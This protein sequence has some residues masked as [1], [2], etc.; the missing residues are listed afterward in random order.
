MGLKKGDIVLV[1]FPFTDL[2]QTKFRPAVVLAANLAINEFTV[3]FVSSQKVETL[4]GGE[5]ALLE[6]DPDFSQ[7]GLRISSK[8]RVTRITT[9]SKQLITR[10]MG[11]LSPSHLQ[12]LDAT[13]IQAFQ[14]SS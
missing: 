1:E 14:L 12:Q 5:S 8:V 13:L 3:C 2:S 6:S 10:R 4:Y 7:T 9:L 11:N